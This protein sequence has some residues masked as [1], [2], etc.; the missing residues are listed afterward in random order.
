MK[1]STIIYYTSN[2]EDEKFEEKIMEKLVE[3]S[4]GLPIISVS[5]K[6]IDLGKNICIGDVGA[7]NTNLY[8]QI[9]VGC[10][11]A[12]TPFVIMAE[13]DCLYPPE[14]FTFVP[15][16]ED[17]CY[18]YENLYILHIWKD[19][20]YCKNVSQC[21]QIVGREHYIKLLKEILKK[22][23]PQES[24]FLG[25]KVFKYAN[26]IVNIKTKRGLRKRTWVYK[27]IPPV[28]NIPYWGNYKL[29]KN[30]LCL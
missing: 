28:D 25:W 21:G 26:P 9:L 14:Y 20:F 19:G 13:A 1:Q 7:N 3:N 18:R 16:E 6:P 4:G 29:L 5:Q 11:K 30:K 8:K 17:V 24:C 10:E 15:D 23:N 2:R 12:T 22:N 27:D